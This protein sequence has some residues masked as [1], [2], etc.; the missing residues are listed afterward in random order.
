MHL[1]AFNTDDSF[2]FGV[3]A[4][5]DVVADKELIHEFIFS[6]EAKAHLVCE[7]HRRVEELLIG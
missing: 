7:V 3:G 5:T 2:Y 1:R 4:S 6:I